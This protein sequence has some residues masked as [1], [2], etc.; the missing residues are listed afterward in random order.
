MN[1]YNTHDILRLGEP[2]MELVDVDEDMGVSQLHYI[3]PMAIISEW[4]SLGGC[5]VC[6]TK[7]TPGPSW[8]PV[9]MIWM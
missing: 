2:V 3:K 5:Y 9:V 4:P 1:K 6:S 7:V 8:E